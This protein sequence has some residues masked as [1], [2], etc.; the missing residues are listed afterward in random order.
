[1]KKFTKKPVTISAIQVPGYG[2]DP[3]E[4]LMELIEEHGWVGEGES[5]IIPTLEGNH[6][7]SPGDWIICGIKGEF[8]P[9][10]PDIFEATYVDADAIDLPARPA[11]NMSFSDALAAVKQGYRLQR[12]GWNGKG[13]FVFLVAG[14]V[15]KVN[16]EPLLS[17]LGEGTEVQYHGHI[18]MRTADGTIV[19]WLASQTDLLAEDWQIVRDLPA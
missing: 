3:S 1:M 11:S 6:T 7:A 19:P 8:Y 9:C 17:I 16:R 2:E 14:S 12:A 18:D 4:A 15:F 10:K 13:M 5:L